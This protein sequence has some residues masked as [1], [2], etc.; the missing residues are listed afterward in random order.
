MSRLAVHI[1]RCGDRGTGDGKPRTEGELARPHALVQPLLLRCQLHTYVVSLDHRP[2]E[3]PGAHRLEH[4]QERE[5]DAGGLPARGLPVAGVNERVDD[6][7]HEDRY[8][9][10]E[11]ACSG[12]RVAPARAVAG[13]EGA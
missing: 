1:R 5:D 10:G 12:Y 6:K 9:R 4:T 8:I 11:A 7:Q 13:A 3:V 2:A